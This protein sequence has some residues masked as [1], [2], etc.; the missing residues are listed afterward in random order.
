[1]RFC[2][3]VFVVLSL[4]ISL[5]AYSAD[6][7]FTNPRLLIRE[8]I[9]LKSKE[10]WRE[11]TLNHWEKAGSIVFKDV[12]LNE[13]PSPFAYSVFS[14]LGHYWI[15]ISGTGQLYEFDPDQLTFR[16]IDKTYY[17]GYNFGSFQ[18][19]RK[20]T[21]YS[22][23]GLGFWHYNNI[24]TYFNTSGKEWER[25]YIPL[26]GPA[27]ILGNFSGYSKSNDKLFVL[28][29]PD[30]F[31]QKPIDI[32][33]LKFFTF[34]F[35]KKSW[36][37]LGWVPNKKLQEAGM[38][39]LEAIF[40]QNLFVI[41]KSS[42]LLII[43]P[44][45]NKLYEYNGLKPNFFNPGFVVTEKGTMLYSYQKETPINSHSTNIDSVDVRK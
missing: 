44:V 31:V 10:F 16:R 17:R 9:D 28:E 38:H 35:D 18:F 14:N 40:I 7:E 37:T 4:T 21:L 24:E 3:R 19:V 13:L 34:D 36:K 15:T 23:G 45:N 11:K 20:D 43:D 30:Y 5:T 1:M 29:L 26:Q 41:P 42:P 25:V 12:N 27:R 32:D 8:R 2:Y 39:S 22:F 33:H 6:I